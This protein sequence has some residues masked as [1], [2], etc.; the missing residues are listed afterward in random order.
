MRG[1]P[2]QIEPREVTLAKMRARSLRLRHANPE[3]YREKA[4]KRYAEKGDEI[5]ARNAASYQRH[6][7]KRLAH[8]KAAREASPERQA[9]SV[10]KRILSRSVGIR[11]RDIPDDLAEAK[12][13]E[14]QIKRAIQAI[15]DD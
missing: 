5:R 15:S 4:R 13:L 9:L 2:G 3:A 11:I 12:A 8:E 7:E 10:A 14:L 1:Y 6:R